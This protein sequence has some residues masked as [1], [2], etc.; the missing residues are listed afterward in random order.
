[1][2]YF[3]ADVCGNVIIMYVAGSETCATSIGKKRKAIY[4]SLGNRRKRPVGYD[5]VNELTKCGIEAVGVD[6]QEMDITDAASV[7]KVIGEAAPDA[8][9]HCAAYTAVDAAEDNVEI[10]RKVNADGTQ[11]I[12]N[13]CK[14]LDCK[15]VYI[16]TDYVFDGEGTRPWEPEDE[17][18][19]LNVY[20]QTKY[21]GELAVQKTLEKYFIVRIS[22]VFGVNG[23]N[24]IKTMLNLGKT[25]DHLTSGE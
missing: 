25:H 14:K 24:F 20:G 1:M 18:H 15:M 6:I 13:V 22:W 17:R 5:V 16:S 11:N 9:V 10:C 19:P 4:E 23:K 21:E 2:K 3:V 8:V 12:A 7:E